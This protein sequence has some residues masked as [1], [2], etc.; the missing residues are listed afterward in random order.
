MAPDCRGPGSGHLEVDEGVTSPDQP[1]RV[2]RP[3]LA[4]SGSFTTN[5]EVVFDTME[6]RTPPGWGVDHRH[7]CRR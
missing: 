2:I 1:M 3:V 5:L 4:L 6:A 7:E